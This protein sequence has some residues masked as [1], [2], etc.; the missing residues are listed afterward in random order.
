MFRHILLTHC[1]YDIRKTNTFRQHQRFIITL[2]SCFYLL[3]RQILCLE[4]EI[5]API[6]FCSFQCL[7]PIAH[8]CFS[9]QFEVVNEA[10][11]IEDTFYSRPTGCGLE[12]DSLNYSLAKWCRRPIEALCLLTSGNISDDDFDHNEPS[13]S[14]EH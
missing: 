2:P 11:C 8:L 7:L 4:T 12:R 9:F 1:R 6:C 3:R 10:V 5:K 13:Q 14:S